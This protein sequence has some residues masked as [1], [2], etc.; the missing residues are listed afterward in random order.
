MENRVPSVDTFVRTSSLGA[1]ILVC[2]QKRPT[3]Q[4]TLCLETSAD[5][6]NSAQLK[7]RVES[8]SSLQVKNRRQKK[9][10][11]FW[12]EIIP[13]RTT[14]TT[15]ITCTDSSILTVLASNGSSKE[16]IPL[17]LVGLAVPG[18]QT[19]FVEMCLVQQPPAIGASITSAQIRDNSSF[20]GWSLEEALLYYYAY[21]LC[22]FRY[23]IF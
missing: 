4:F 14:F 11:G 8:R 2:V 3:R 6:V 9:R 5:E 16:R 13:R 20:T 21:I 23:A 17:S 19:T 18:L 10:S 1:V 15:T 12:P 22:Q 7:A